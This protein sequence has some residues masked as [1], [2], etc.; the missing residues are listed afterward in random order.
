MFK[1]ALGIA[2]T[3]SACALPQLVSA[4]VG[5]SINIGQPGFYGRIDL[6]DYPPP[7]L[8]YEQ[9]LII[10]HFRVQRSPLYLRVPPG[11][12]KHWRKHCREYDAC[13]RPVYFVQDDW[14]D[15]VYAPAYRQR[16]GR[17]HD[18]EGGQNHDDDHN[19]GSSHDSDRG[20]DQGKGHGKGHDKGHG[21]DHD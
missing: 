9:P 21:N 17:G 3:A 7:R 4:A 18:E 1:Q 14:Y 6:G 8:I 2:L 11:H 13:G 15:K 5:V 12:A 20:G 16:H 19:H 10:E